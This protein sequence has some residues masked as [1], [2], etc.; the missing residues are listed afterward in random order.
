[1][2][3]GDFDADGLTGLAILVACAAAARHGRA[4]VRAQPPRGGPRPVAAG[5]RRRRATPGASVIV[6][7]DCGTTQRMPRSPKPRR[8]G[9]TCWSRTTTASRRSCRR[10]RDRQSPCARTAAIRIGGWPAA[11]SPSSSR[12]CCWPTSR[13]DPPPRWISRIWR[14]SAPSRTWRRCL[15][16]TGRSPGSASSACARAPRRGDRGPSRAGRR[17]APAKVDLETVA[18]VARAAHQRR[19]SGRGSGRRRRPAP[20]RRPRGSRS[21]GRDPGRREPGP[22]PSDS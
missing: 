6:T 1:M 20:D 5:D 14:P 9:S 21:P 18:F 4:T 15:A 16:R 12:S 19:R 2:V 7:V 11:A 22:P 3:F 17:R 13:A 8:A 10:P